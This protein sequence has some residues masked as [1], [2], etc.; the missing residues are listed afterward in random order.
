MIANKNILVI[1]S[2]Y[3]TST[4]FFIRT[5]LVSKNF[6]GIIAWQALLLAAFLAIISNKCGYTIR[7]KTVNVANE[8]KYFTLRAINYGKF[9]NSQIST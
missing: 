3:K 1:I 2:L 8:N 6:D 5:Q 9:I 7:P 4:F